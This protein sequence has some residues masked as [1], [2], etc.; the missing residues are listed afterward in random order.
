MQHLPPQPVSL[1]TILEWIDSWS[2][3]TGIRRCRVADAVD[4]VCAEDV[5]AAADLPP[6]DIAAISGFALASASTVGAGDYNPLLFELLDPDRPAGS[7]CAVPVEAGRPLPGSTDAVIA[8]AE[9]DILGGRLSIQAAVAPGSG[10]IAR[11]EEL[12]T[13]TTLIS[14]GRRIMP[15]HGSLMTALGMIDVALF[16]APRVALVTT[17]APFGAALSAVIAPLIERDG[18]RLTLTMDHR[19][20]D[21]VERLLSG[22]E[23]DLVVVLGGTGYLENASGRDLL[24]RMGEIS[25]SAVAISPGTGLVLGHAGSRPV[26]VLPGSLLNAVVAYELVV[27]RLVRRLAGL[28]PELPYHRI[29]APLRSG[30]SS[31]IGRTEMA[32]LRR[33][34]DGFEALA[35]TEDRLLTSLSM[36][37]GFTVIAENSEG[38]APDTMVEV[39]LFDAP[40]CE[41]SR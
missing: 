12:A 22:Q 9:A 6:T 18:G 29:R 1:S 31:R 10:V 3:V 32:R 37:D 4:N 25:A 21:D 15:W 16:E 27:S 14:R 35:V 7:G 30:V 11:G 41:T 36:A 17:E 34:R 2:P 40:F 20:T 19:G 38:F 24:A 26:A 5:I 39:C 13:G 23:A 8:D 28:D 33:T